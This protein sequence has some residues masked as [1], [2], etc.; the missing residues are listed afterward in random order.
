MDIPTIVSYAVLGILGL[1][2]LIGAL[3]G[4]SRGISRQ[5]IRTLT[6]V[7][8][9]ALSILA[10]KFLSGQIYAYFDGKTGE[11]LL[12]QIAN[13]GITVNGE[14]LNV[15]DFEWLGNFDPEIISYILAIPLSLVVLPLVFVILFIIISALMLIVHAIVSGVLGFRKKKNNA[16]TRLLGMALG[17]VQGALVTVVLLV[18]IL[19]IASTASDAIETM[20]QNE[21]KSEA[22]L[23]IIELY[24]NNVKGAVE[25]PV[26]KTLTNFGG[27]ILYNWLSTT[28]IGGESVKMTEQI[29]PVLSVYSE[30]S[31]NLAGADFTNLTPENQAAIKS[32]IAKIENSNYFAPLLA[33]V[34]KGAA[35][36]ALESEAIN[37]MEEPLGSVIKS[38]ISIFKDASR[39]NLA[40]DINTFCDLY[41][42]LSDE[43]VLAAMTAGEG[44][45]A[46]DIM[47]LL[48]K[49]DENNETTLSRAISILGSNTRTQPIVTSLTKLSISMISG[50]NPEQAE[51]IEEVYNEIKTGLNEVVQIKREDFASDEEHKAA[52]SD[53]IESVI[54][55][56]GI[57]DAEFVEENREEIEEVLGVVADHVI[58]NFGDVE[59]VTDAH[60]TEV[61]V[62]Y[63]EAYLNGEFDDM[64]Q[65]SDINPD[66]LGN[67]GNQ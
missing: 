49:K 26:V 63:Y 17:A 39:D 52:V 58:E 18:P 41:F 11:E 37:T 4:L 7:A 1:L 31:A 9:I 57:I 67:L 24:D 20:R 33:D 56:S 46:P 23:E 38:V 61:I 13:M 66:D 3:K 36:T 45:E 44:E 62:E 10:V 27:N 51:Q 19:G 5:L 60:I 65:D 21:N 25:T 6:V 43:G 22:E 40:T 34:V 35:V 42:L 54:V 53:S 29:Q 32:I 50:S 48:S 47:Q 14:P 15:N 59:E 8:S 30:Y 12:A 64:L 2:V 16:L 55:D 28:K